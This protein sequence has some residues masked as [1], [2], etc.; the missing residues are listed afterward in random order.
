MDFVGW[1]V[2]WLMTFVHDILSVCLFYHHH[3]NNKNF[4]NTKHVH[5]KIHVYVF[6]F[7]FFFI[8]DFTRKKYMDHILFFNN[9]DKIDFYFSSFCFVLFLNSSSFFSN[10]MNGF[11]HFTPTTIN[12]QWREKKIRTKSKLKSWMMKHYETIVFFLFCSFFF[13][14]LSIDL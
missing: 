3:L 4:L 11:F 7:C 9:K 2:G 1:L 5:N 13:D 12:N 10:L 6:C 14:Y 8:F